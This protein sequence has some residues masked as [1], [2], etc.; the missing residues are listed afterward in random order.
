MFLFGLVFVWFG[1][2]HCSCTLS[3]SSSMAAL[4]E[5]CEERFDGDIPFRY[6]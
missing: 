5:F 3:A 1:V 4:P 2:A 6:E